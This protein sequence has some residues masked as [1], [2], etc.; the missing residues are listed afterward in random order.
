[1]LG[2]T[3][4]TGTVMNIRTVTALIAVPIVSAVALSVPG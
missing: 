3:W 2:D 1:M 4:R